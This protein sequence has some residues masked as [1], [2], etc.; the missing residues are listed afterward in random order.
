MPRQPR[1]KIEDTEGSYH[2]WN[3]IACKR[4]EYPL[5]APYVRHKFLALLKFYLGI[6]GRT[7]LGQ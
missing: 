1:L 4:G 7:G 3:A 2:A 5:A 6:Y